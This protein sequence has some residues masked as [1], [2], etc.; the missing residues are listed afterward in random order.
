MRARSW[1]WRSA[2]SSNA[3]MSLPPPEGMIATVAKRL[4]EAENRLNATEKWR[5]NGKKHSDAN[6][7]GEQS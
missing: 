7:S 4:T 5:L 6:A 1:P 3:T 2:L